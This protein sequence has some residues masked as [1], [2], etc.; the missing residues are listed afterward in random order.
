V[1]VALVGPGEAPVLTR[2]LLPSEAG[3]HGTI[4]E[5][6][7]RRLGRS[8]RILG[9]PRSPRRSIRILGGPRLLDSDLSGA[10]QVLG[11]KLLGGKVVVN[12]D[13]SEELG[14]VLLK[15]GGEDNAERIHLE[16]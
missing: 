9:S 3:A 5:R 4:L 10:R 1:K 14:S 16:S 11:D 12:C 15:S 8:I 6:N 7:L 13:A 2:G